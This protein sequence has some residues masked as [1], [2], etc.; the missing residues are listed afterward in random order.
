MF[1]RLDECGKGHARA[2]EGMSLWGRGVQAGKPD[3]LQGY[4]SS[5][6]RAGASAQAVR[7]GILGV[8]APRAD[9]GAQ[10][11]GMTLLWSEIS[12]AWV[13]IWQMSPVTP[14]MALAKEDRILPCHLFKGS[15]K[16][17]LG[18]E[19]TLGT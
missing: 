3:L 7:L 19:S 18:V 12:S 9:A 13:P 15:P 1:I 6:D 10:V 8:P 11:W 16:S 2:S 14:C 17:P 4:G 5:W